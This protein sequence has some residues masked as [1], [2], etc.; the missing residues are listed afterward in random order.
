MCRIRY[1]A[2]ATAALADQQKHHAHGCMHRA[3]RWYLHLFLLFL[4]NCRQHRFIRV[5]QYFI[6]QTFLFSNVMRCAAMQQ[7]MRMWCARETKAVVVRMSSWSF[8]WG[9]PALHLCGCRLKMPRQGLP[10][11]FCWS[12]RLSLQHIY[13]YLIHTH[14]LPHAHRCFFWYR[15]HETKKDEN[16]SRICVNFAAMQY[17]AFNR[18]ELKQSNNRQQINITYDKWIWTPP[19]ELFCLSFCL[20]S[21]FVGFHYHALWHGVHACGF[22]PP[23][24]V[25]MR[26]NDDPT[27]YNF[28]ERK[29]HESCFRLHVAR[30]LLNVGVRTIII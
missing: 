24:L 10:L 5:F 4:Q 28:T 20:C 17:N 23:F 26:Q 1:A 12:A 3:A 16:I 18:C 25:R 8:V 7:C 14:T 19:T 15:L 30:Y 6:S 13:I 9:E 2:A 29:Q 22:H 21:S 27:T 11:W